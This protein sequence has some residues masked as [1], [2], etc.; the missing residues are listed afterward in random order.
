MTTTILNS[1]LESAR[2]MPMFIA[3]KKNE[4]DDHLFT[5]RALN[6]ML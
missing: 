3:K 5:T 2:K 1:M 4:K 6:P